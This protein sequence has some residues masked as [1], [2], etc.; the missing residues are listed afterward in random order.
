MAVI[1]NTPYE[2][3]DKPKQVLG[4]D[5][6]KINGEIVFENVTYVYENNNTKVL[7]NFSLTIPAGQ[8]IAIIGSSGAG[9]TTFVR[10]LMRFFNLNSGEITIDGVNINSIS[11]SQ[12]KLET[13]KH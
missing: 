7:D 13:T 3:F 6:K 4:Q 8:K 10:L 5:G 1:L 9:K 2:I 12:N 11:S